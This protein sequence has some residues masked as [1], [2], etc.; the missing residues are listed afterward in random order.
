MCC[1]NEFIECI[2][3]H[4]SKLN[5]HDFQSYIDELGQRSYSQHNQ[6]INA[7]K[8]L[9]EKVLDRKFKVKFDRP[10]KRISLPTV[11]SI[12][13][14][15]SMIDKARNSKH[16]AV[17]LT[18]YDLGIRREEL[19]NLKWSDIDR[20]QMIVRINQGK[21]KKDRITPLSDRLLSLYEV[22]YRDFPHLGYV[23]QGQLGGK[24][25]ATSVANVIKYTSKGI[26]KN[27]TPHVLRHSFATH[28][29]DNG[30]DIRIIQSILGHSRSTTTEIYTHV[31]TRSFNNIHRC[32]LKIVS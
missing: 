22:Y 24:Y 28:L 2:G 6:I 29:M 12:E 18:L 31:S 1:I 5:S 17:I 14:I 27:V 4:E 8:F 30:I 3:K 13:E 20:N 16:R 32:N 19:I 21:G 25:S 9:Y 11:L 10:K 26:N 15:Q 23:F 7:L